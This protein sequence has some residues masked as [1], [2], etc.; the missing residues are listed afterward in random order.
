MICSLKISLPSSSY[1]SW[2][3]LQRESHELRPKSLIERAL[4]SCRKEVLTHVKR[5]V[6]E[7]GDEAESIPQEKIGW[8]VGQCKSVTPA[9]RSHPIEDLLQSLTSFLIQLQDP[10]HSSGALRKAFGGLDSQLRETLSK[11]VW[12]AYQ[13]PMEDSQFGEHQIQEDP[14]ILLRIL[15]EEG[16]NCIE[17]LI[18]CL[19]RVQTISFQIEE[20]SKI[21][22]ALDRPM[23][24]EDRLRDCRHVD[25][26]ALK[27]YIGNQIWR[28]AGGEKDPSFASGDL[29]YGERMADREP[30]RLNPVLQDLVHTLER[31]QA[32]FERFEVET[33]TFRI[34]RKE[35]GLEASEAAIQEKF[36]EKIAEEYMKNEISYVLNMVS[37]IPDVRIRMALAKLCAQKNGVA[38]SAYIRNF[39]IDP[40]NQEALI[41]IAKL[42]AQQDGWGTAENIGNFGIDPAN[43]EALIEIAKLCAQQDGR[44]MPGNI[45]NFGINPANQEALIEIAMICAQQDG[46]GTAENMQNFGID[47]ANQEALIEIAKLCA[48]QDGRGTAMH[49]QNVEIDPANQE[50]LIEIAKLCAQ[51]NGEGTALNIQNFGIDPANQEAL[52]E[53]AK[54]CAQQDGR[55]TALNMQN[56]GINPANQEALIEIAKLCAQQN[57]EGTALNIQN[58]EIDP[59]NQEALIE[60]AKLCAQ[61]DGR[62]T[63]LNMQN[64]GIDPANQEALIEIAKLCAQQNGEGTAL[65]IQNF[66]ID[67]ANQEALIEIAKLCAQQDGLG[68]AEN[69]QNLGIDPANQKALIEIAKLCAFSSGFLLFDH[70]SSLFFSSFPE[71]TYKRLRLYCLVSATFQGETTSTMKRYLQDLYGVYQI[72]CEKPQYQFLKKFIS[73]DSEEFSSLQMR[74]LA[75]IAYIIHEWGDEE[76]PDVFKK[77]YEKAISYRNSNLSLF[78]LRQLTEC[79]NKKIFQ[80]L[81]VR[82]RKRDPLVH[83]LL[84]M[85]PV[86]KWFSELE[87]GEEGRDAIGILHR[88]IQSHRDEFKNLNSGLMQSWLLA[89]QALDEMS[90]LSHSQKIYIL[91]AVCQ[92][93]EIEHSLEDLKKRLS[94]IHILCRERM[95]PDEIPSEGIASYLAEILANNIRED[96]YLNL[97]N[98]ENLA[99]KFAATL[100]TMRM[101]AMWKTYETRIRLTN[102]PN[103]REAFQ[104]IIVSILEG[105]FQFFRYEEAQRTKHVAKIR[106]A[107][108]KIW[109]RWK[110]S[111][112]STSIRLSPSQ[113]VPA[114]SFRAFL[115][116]KYRDGHLERPGGSD[117]LTLLVG[118][119]QNADQ[120]E[121]IFEG[122]R[123]ACEKSEDP[124]L[125]A[126][127]LLMDL[128][129]QPHSETQ[130]LERL[131]DLERVLPYLSSFEI[132]NDIAGLKRTLERQDAEGKEVILTD[133]DDWQDLFL[134]GTEV[135]GSCLRIDGDPKLN[136][137][138]LAYLMDGKN[139]I[140][141]VKDPET[142]KI[143]AR[144]L[145]R[146]LW[147]ETTKQ[148]VLFQDR[149][150]PRPCSQEMEAAL[151]RLA[152]ARALELGLPLC[153]AEARADARK[154]TDRIVSLGSPAPFEYEDG[155]D[156]VMKEGR[157]AIKSSNEVLHI[158]EVAS[159]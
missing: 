149:I 126:Q 17:R 25:Q 36:Y 106:E 23:S 67:P 29:H 111:K 103:V 31:E 108:G 102:D 61:Q 153:I 112:Y 125:R 74:R 104:G 130:I 46:W 145:F 44:G 4:L 117:G 136:K 41:K 128:Y 152:K 28:Q 99:E 26:I 143:F 35:R 56:F 81:V 79:R 154:S 38:T 137:C 72:E 2:E 133:S 10:A 88:C 124:I 157:F 15:D 120:R 7:V 119:L 116:E 159:G 6:L 13:K 63:A 94:Y 148:P 77:A 156:G 121:E 84:P 144:C 30:A 155:A 122:C 80:E 75:V 18:E 76:I 129:L 55:G 78:C 91:T 47:P 58:F 16:N 12:Y 64:F 138:L 27:E 39:G 87:Q 127:A 113:G 105:R 150:Y 135:S 101:P 45:G 96:D 51:Q 66:E 151:N 85:A 57:G 110:T 65:N 90:G 118:F 146:L 158:E 95:M 59:A 89:C 134:C 98:I 83:G 139:R 37:R 114:F 62:G 132:A 54:L 69:I 24:L 19:Y 5:K 34:E 53:I 1:F 42:C 131:S 32:V 20:I 8:I 115:E 60:I 22:V 68:T 3:A 49:I 86:S 140:L 50:A 147:N 48:Q 33:S 40:A 92:N 109:E 141:A 142:G 21:Y 52:I 43:Q 73:S 97:R 71:E 93:L 82:D 100:G 14:R 9:V 11:W 123:S 70:M 107:H